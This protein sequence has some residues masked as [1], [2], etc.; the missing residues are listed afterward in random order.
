M[1]NKAV[2]T[3][4]LTETLPNLTARVNG[5]ITKDSEVS[6]FRGYC[7]FASF[8]HTNSPAQSGSKEFRHTMKG[9]TT[10]PKTQRSRTSRP[11]TNI[12]RLR[13][14][15]RGGQASDLLPLVYHHNVFWIQ[16]VATELFGGRRM[17]AEAIP[18]ASRPSKPCLPFT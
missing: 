14:R 9:L 8:P 4:A 1:Q 17:M 6:A 3:W 13:A 2:C 15:R 5:C 10:V 18:P 12:T 11:H 16:R 7:G